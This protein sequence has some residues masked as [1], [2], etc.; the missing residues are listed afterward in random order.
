MKDRK[1]CYMA[2]MTGCEWCVIY[3][4]HS[5]KEAK[6]WA[7]AEFYG[8]CEFIDVR[9]KWLKHVDVSDLPYGDMDCKEGLKRGAYT[10][11]LDDCPVCGSV[12]RL[13]RSDVDGEIRCE[14]CEEKRSDDE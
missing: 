9:V 4:V 13:E 11:I 1:R 5:F 14:A 6:K 3:I 7:V 8:E 12:T 10:W 2:W